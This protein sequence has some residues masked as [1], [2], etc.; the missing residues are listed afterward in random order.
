MHEVKMWLLLKL[1]DLEV[2]YAS[3]LKYHK[4]SFEYSYN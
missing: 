4:T 3:Q 2:L 1:K